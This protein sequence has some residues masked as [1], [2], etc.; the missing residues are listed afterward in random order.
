MSSMEDQIVPLWMHRD[1]FKQIPL[2]EKLLAEL[3]AGHMDIF[4]FRSSTLQAIENWC[5][6]AITA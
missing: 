4:M 2:Q 5:T 6:S 3:H 1:I